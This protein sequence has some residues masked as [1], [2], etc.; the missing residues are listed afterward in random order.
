MVCS[1]VSQSL[2]GPVP[3]LT[4]L[5]LTVTR[6]SRAVW[7]LF[8]QG[9]G[10]NECMFM[11]F[12]LSLAHINTAY[13]AWLI[14]EYAFESHTLRFRFQ[15]IQHCLKQQHFQRTKIVIFKPEALINNQNGIEQNSLLVLDAVI[16]L[17]LRL[18]FLV[19]V[20]FT[21]LVGQL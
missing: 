12:Q 17:K 6:N 3:L 20:H 5:T 4:A 8:N 7:V 11:L 15:V 9:I 16:G 21:R 19:V 13:L 1:L 18:V 2:V 14:I 10:E